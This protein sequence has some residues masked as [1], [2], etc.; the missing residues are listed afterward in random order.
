MSAA[1][2]T[3]S[4]LYFL[5]NDHVLNWAIAFFESL[6]AL[7]PDLRL[8]MIPFNDRV[9]ALAKLS[10]RYRFEIFNDPSLAA[11]DEI[12][13]RFFPTQEIPQ[14]TFRKFAVFW[15]PLQRFIFSDVDIV[16]L[17]GVRQFADAYARSQLDLL[18][19]DEEIHQVYADE[20]FRRKMMDTHGARGFNTGFWAARRGLFS[21]EQVQ[22]LADEAL[23]MAG[24][25]NRGTYEQP[26][27]NYCCDVSHVRYAHFADFI[28]DLTRRFLAVQHGIRHGTDGVHYIHDTLSPDY[29][30]RIPFLHWA[31]TPANEG[32]PYRSIFLKY[33]LRS[34]TLP[35]R[36]W[37][38]LTG[39][40]QR[41]A[42]N[43]IRWGRETNFIGRTYK[44]LMPRALQ[45]RVTRFLRRKH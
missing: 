30:K 18:H 35:R 28:P 1:A 20:Q 19:A 21:L 23:P 45:E 8:V 24:A 16:F 32:M 38:R 31:G 25:F 7:D 33:R 14:R 42:W 5:A 26:F 17:E 3:S 10:D 2:D 43:T 41:I 40:P 11:L 13:G 44:R 12:G 36:T 4:G 6:R 37:V 29:G 15:G 27:V 34:E 39:V 9:D 22:R